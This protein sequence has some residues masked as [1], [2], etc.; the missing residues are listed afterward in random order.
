MES[1]TMLT[2]NIVRDFF[3]FLGKERRCHLLF[4]PFLQDDKFAWFYRK[5][6]EN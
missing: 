2:L 6:T 3:S 5:L 1:L 4:S